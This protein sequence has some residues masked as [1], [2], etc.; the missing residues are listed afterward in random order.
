MEPD[1]LR[2]TH[3]YAWGATECLSVRRVAGAGTRM[4]ARLKEGYCAFKVSDATLD[5]SVALRESPEID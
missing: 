4:C 5:L 2:I 1:N 3:R